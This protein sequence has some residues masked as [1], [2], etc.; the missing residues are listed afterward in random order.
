MNPSLSAD[1]QRARILID[2]RR[3]RDAIPYLL[4]HLASCPNDIYCLSVL[5]E[6]HI[7]L[8]KLIDATR[9]I[10]SALAISPADDKLMY[11]KSR[12]AFYK[13]RL[14]T[15]IQHLEEAIAI[16]PNQPSY[17]AA[18]GE[19][20][21]YKND[22]TQV[23]AKAEQ[24]LALD[25]E[26]SIC[27]SLRSHALFQLGKT[28]T[29]ISDLEHMLSQNPE[30]VGLHC[31]LGWKWLEVGD[32]P[33]ATGYLRE[34]L[35]LDPNYDWANQGILLAMQ[36]KYWVCRP[37]IKYNFLFKTHV[38]RLLLGLLVGF[39][40]LGYWISVLFLPLYIVLA[41]MLLSPWLVLPIGNIML[42]FSRSGRT[43][44][45][46]V[47][48]RI[49]S[50]IGFLL[51]MIIAA[52]AGYWLM[53][54]KFLLAIGMVAGALIL[55]LGSV[56]LSHK[57]VRWPLASFYTWLLAVLGIIGIYRTIASGH[58]FNG[59]MIAMFIALYIF[60]LFA[61]KVFGQLRK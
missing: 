50:A 40:L 33:R 58:L 29:A 34:S 52:T 46:S 17:F 53:T 37:Y 15:S 54:T 35:R 31:S 21:M 14:D 47:Q 32:Y 56:Y 9:V 41:V 12:V 6:C 1:I 11:L 18:W 28:A 55:P 42:L 19:V 3:Y 27:L 10:D 49:S 45:P 57:K 30:D 4:E 23:L 25:P 5:A 51:L 22:F 38:R 61:L 7:N 48:T 26:N 44:L 60:Q 8:G 20:L 16:N 36:A 13:K 24:G 43:A 2:Q 59:W 39:P